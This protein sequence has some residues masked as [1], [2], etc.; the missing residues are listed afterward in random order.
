MIGPEGRLIGLDQDPSSIERARETLGNALQVS[1]H[2]E[3]F[4]SLGKILDVL[5]IP[6]VD[7]VILDV[8]F[9]S[10]QIEDPMRGFSFERPGPLDM[11][12][13]PDAPVRAGDL[14][15]DLSQDEL[16]RIFREYGQER[17][18][19]RFAGAICE[20]REQRPFETTDDLAQVI[21]GCLPRSLRFEKGRRPAWMRRHPATRVFQA[22]RIAVNRELDVLRTS[23]PLIWGRLKPGGRLAVITFHSLEDKIVKEIFRGLKQAGDAV[24]VTKKP[25]VASR[26]EQRMNPRSRSAELR[27][28]ERIK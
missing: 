18:A 26:E 16:V 2:H 21:E 6:L 7:A 27:V 13:N 1:L 17:Q 14:I 22:L 3:N 8:G 12:M 19:E 11:R 5:N 28:A 20:R 25:L 15:N 24:L 23:L 4:E 9:S 10:D